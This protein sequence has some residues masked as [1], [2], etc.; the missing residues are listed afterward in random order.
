[1]IAIPTFDVTIS[2]FSNLEL[3]SFELHTDW[4]NRSYFANFI[5][6]WNHLAM[7]VAGFWYLYI[8]L[9][10]WLSTFF[11]YCF[12]CYHFLIKV[13]DKSIHL[14]SYQKFLVEETNDS[15]LRNVPIQ[16]KLIL[17]IT[18]ITKGVGNQE[19]LHNVKDMYG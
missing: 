10:A 4:T 2:V 13:D 3:I 5:S 12:S 1:M 14:K 15:V 9:A 16:T 11:F 8:R 19:F 18:N 17:V 7:I 6:Q